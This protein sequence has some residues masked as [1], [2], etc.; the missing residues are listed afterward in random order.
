[1]FFW[2]HFGDV[3]DC[4][5]GSFW[6]PFGVVFGPRRSKN[7]KGAMS[8]FDYKTICFLIILNPKGGTDIAKVRKKGI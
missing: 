2:M 3:F 7:R 1:M 6:Y 5:L 8:I 4:F